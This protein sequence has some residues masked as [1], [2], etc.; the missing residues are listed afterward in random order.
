MSDSESQSN[1]FDKKSIRKSSGSDSPLPQRK[2]KRLNRDAVD[3]DEDLFNQIELDQKKTPQKVEKPK[4][5]KKLMRMF[6]DG[7]D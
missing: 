6:Y 2:F 3:S 7:D 1:P 5:A 4:F